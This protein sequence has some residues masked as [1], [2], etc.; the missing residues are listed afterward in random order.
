MY[1]L[2]LPFNESQLCKLFLQSCTTQNYQNHSTQHSPQI[3]VSSVHPQTSSALLQLYNELLPGLLDINVRHRADATQL[4]SAITSWQRANG[5][6]PCVKLLSTK[7]TFEHIIPTKSSSSKANG[8]GKRNSVSRNTR[9]HWIWQLIKTLSLY[10][11][12][13]CDN[14]L[15]QISNDLYR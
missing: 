13:N 8:N 5:D 4:Y 7:W 14:S 9:Q 3:T 10:F 12:Y 15:T 1:G 2:Q 11:V 6:D